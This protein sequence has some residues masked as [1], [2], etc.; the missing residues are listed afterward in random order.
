M[1]ATKNRGKIREIK[2]ILDGMGV[3]IFSLYDYPEVPEIEEDGASFFENALKKARSVSLHTG[4]T[5]IADDSGLEVDALNGRPGVH[6]ARYSGVDA[7]DGKN[8]ERLLKELHGVPL[9]ERKAAF[10]CILVLYESNGTYQSFD[11]TLEGFIGVEPRG[12]EGFGY[13]PVFVVPEY[14]CTV[15][16]LS[17]DVKNEISHRAKALKKLRNSLHKKTA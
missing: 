13:D 17:P 12:R 9:K 10:K 14:E 3:E 5:V 7:S 16:E 11:G 15:S 1:L 8:N 6:S 2:K 4:E